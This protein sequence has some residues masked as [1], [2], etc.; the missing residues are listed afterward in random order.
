VQP[1]AIRDRLQQHFF[2]CSWNEVY[3]FLEA[4]VQITGSSRVAGALDEVLRCE[5]AAYRFLEGKIVE[6]TDEKEIAALEEALRARD[7]FSPSAAHLQ[8]ALELLSDR[9]NPDFRNSIKES[10]SAVE[11]AARTITGDEAAT[12]GDALKALERKHDLHKALKEGF[13]KLYGYTS[14][15]NGIR[16]AMTEEPSVGGAE[17]KYFLLSCTSFVNYL[18]GRVGGG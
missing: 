10:I 12:L 2:T 9:Q 16:H 3:D 18:K 5:L 6:I 17:A 11:A 7:R 1:W 4:V 15:E 13:L 14:D 8:R